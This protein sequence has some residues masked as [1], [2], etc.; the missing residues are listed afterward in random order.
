MDP[1][2]DPRQIGDGGGDGPPIPGESGMGPPSPIHGKSGMAVG[3]GIGGS[4]S[5]PWSPQAHIGGG[6]S[7]R[8]RAPP[9]APP[10]PPAAAPPP[11]RG[12]RPPAESPP[13]PARA[14]RCHVKAAAIWLPS[15]PAALQQLELSL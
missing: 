4:E 13:Q 9:G 10:P 8:P 7:A 2:P 15:H 3:M 12:A 14:C 5:V 6:D 11:R 1:G